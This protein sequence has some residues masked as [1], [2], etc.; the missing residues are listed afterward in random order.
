MILNINK[1]KLKNLKNNIC[2]KMLSPEVF[3]FVIESLQ[4]LSEMK[5][6]KNVE[7]MKE[8]FEVFQNVYQEL[9]G[10][11]YQMD[12]GKDHA[13]MKSIYRNARMKEIDLSDFFRWA[14]TH[15]SSRIKNIGLIS[16]P[17][18]VNMY[19]DS[20]KKVDL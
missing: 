9:H 5:K 6:E 15:Y 8:V 2:P 20:K 16:L 13:I 19:I 11:K 4:Y 7:A 18:L 14:L 17:A 1:N 12:Y 3:D 10:V